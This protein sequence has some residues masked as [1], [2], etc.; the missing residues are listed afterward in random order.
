M[1]SL[2]KVGRAVL[3]TV[4]TPSGNYGHDWIIRHYLDFP[5]LLP[6]NVRIQHG[7]YT[8][9][10]PETADLRTDQPLML[11][12]SKRIAAEWIDLTRR[13]VEILG[14]PFVH[15]RHMFGIQKRE[16]AQG[17]VVFPQHSTR[18]SKT[19]ND[20]EK[21]CRDLDALPDVY[22]PV[23]I[24]LHF[25][26]WD[27][28]KPLFESHGYGRIVTAGRSRQP[29]AGFAKRFYEILSRHQYATSN[30]ILT[31]LFYAVEMGI[32]FFVYGPEPFSYRR[33]SGEATFRMPY[34]YEIIEFFRGPTTT[35][36][37]TQRQLVRS[38]IGLDDSIPPEELRATLI[39]MFWH[40]ELRAYPGR[41]VRNLRRGS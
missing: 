17:T 3:D 8:N 24:C 29:E 5:R 1:R 21:Y 13:P 39:D 27:E 16:D 14:S 30:D 37:E 38:E 34:F 18:N 20:V 7:W 12:W 36:T 10:R 33:E 31:G 6:M 23:T 28:L 15:F 35:S 32:P 40:S 19:E 26:D 25:H 22:R 2:R 11:V 41:F 4:G 9:F